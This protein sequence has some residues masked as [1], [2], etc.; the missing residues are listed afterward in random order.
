VQHWVGLPR[1]IE[2]RGGKACQSMVGQLKSGM[3]A[4]D[5]QSRRLAKGGESM[6]DRA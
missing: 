1:A 4:G 3:L 5:K 2:R 6:G